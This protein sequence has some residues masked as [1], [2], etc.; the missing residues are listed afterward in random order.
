MEKMGQ[1]NREKT[2]E[3]VVHARGMVAKGYFE[4]R[5]I[6]CRLRSQPVHGAARLPGRPCVLPWCQLT[7][8]QLSDKY[9]A[10]CLGD[11][12]CTVYWCSQVCK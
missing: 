7:W 9:V 1:F 3:R 10:P 5:Y 6:L 4:V 8:S 11:R 2:P 12:C